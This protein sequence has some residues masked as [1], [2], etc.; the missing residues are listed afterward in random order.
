MHRGALRVYT[1]RQK[2]I[3]GGAIL[4]LNG[5]EGFRKDLGRVQY[6]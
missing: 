6:Y 3:I 5:S 2:V 1:T 4:D